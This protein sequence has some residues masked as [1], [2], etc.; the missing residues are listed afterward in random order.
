MIKKTIKY[1]TCILI[2]YVIFC[3]ITPFNKHLRNRSIR[4][5]ISYL[6]RILDKGYDDD[7]QR[8]FPEGK[9]FSNAILALSTIEYCEKNTRQNAAYAKIVDNCIRRIQSDRS[10]RVFNKN[11]TPEF[12]MFFNGWSNLVYASYINSQLIEFSSISQNVIEASKQIE[13]RLTAIQRD[14]LQ[15]LNTY[16]SS[17]WPADNLIGVIS[18][19]DTQLQ[20]NWISEI[21]AGATHHSG[22][23]NHASSSTSKIRGSSNAMMIY[24][25]SKAGYKEIEEYNDKYKDVFVD[26]YIG[27]QLVQENVDGSNAMDVDSGPVILGYGASATIMNIKAQA[28]LK[29]TKARRSWA[30]MNTISAPV[31]IFN[32]KFYIFKKEPMLDLFMLWGCT[33]L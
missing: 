3:W 18:L 13:T 11:M 33:E 15:I 23:I 32:R 8:R 27:I 22:L 4:N 6:S 21:F 28:S 16:P 14:S 29:N 26:E 17:N 31:N 1:I 25:L 30:A 5:Q 7:L 2:G 10:M 9:L 24:C 19:K 12:G 20:Q